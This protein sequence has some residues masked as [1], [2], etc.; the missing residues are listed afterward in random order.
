MGLLSAIH[1]PRGSLTHSQNMSCVQNKM[2]LISLRSWAIGEMLRRAHFKISS[3]QTLLMPGSPASNKAAMI[4]IVVVNIITIILIINNEI[5]M[6]CTL[7][8]W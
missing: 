5:I 8:F 1:Q 6:N 4:I 2:I 3:G 7:H